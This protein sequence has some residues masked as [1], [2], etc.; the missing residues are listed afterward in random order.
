MGHPDIQLRE[1]PGLYRKLPECE[2]STVEQWHCRQQWYAIQPV[3][4][5]C[6]SGG[7]DSGI[8]RVVPITSSQ[9]GVMMVLGAG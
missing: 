6:E 7:E 1:E 3:E 9:I 5:E 2:W 4:E 8:E